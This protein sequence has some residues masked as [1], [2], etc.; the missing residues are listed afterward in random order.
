M[1]I[2]LGDF[3][4]K[5]GRENIFKPTIWNECL[6]QD[7]NDKGAGIVNF[8]ASKNLVAKST[9]LL[10]RNNRKYTWTSPDGKTRNQIDHILIDRRRHSRILDIRIIRRTDHDTDHYLVA[11]K[12]RE[13]LA[14]SKQAAQ[15]F[16][17]E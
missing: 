2:L 5:V 15:K 13:N 11:T 9:T 16:D 7:S 1:E 14:I 4:A 17:G 10:H 3:K 8:T 6:H 12:F